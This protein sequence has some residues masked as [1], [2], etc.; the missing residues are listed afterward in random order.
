MQQANLLLASGKLDQLEALAVSS[1]IETV[2]LLPEDD[3]RFFAAIN[4]ARAGEKVWN[5]V[6]L[7]AYA[8]GTL[9]VGVDA[10]KQR[11]AIRLSRES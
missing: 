9:M 4:A 7:V 10:L 5:I 3:Q 11:R 6:F 2:L 1:G 8:V